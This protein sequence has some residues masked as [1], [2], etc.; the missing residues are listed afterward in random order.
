M[1]TTRRLWFILFLL[2]V[3]VMA[4]PVLADSH[5]R[6][7]SAD[8]SGAMTLQR[9]DSSTETIDFIAALQVG[10]RGKNIVIDVIGAGFVPGTTERI[11]IDVIDAGIVQRQ[12][13]DAL[14]QTSGTITLGRDDGSQ[15]L[16]NHTSTG[17][18]RTRGQDVLLSFISNGTLPDGENIVID[19]ISAGVK[20][21]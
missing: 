4:A 10:Q 17:V 19:V 21:G 5:G 20:S 16:I 11:V 14:F 8:I 6:T 13:N 7:L 12:G 18:L 15:L 9:Q 3:S 2:V 1:K